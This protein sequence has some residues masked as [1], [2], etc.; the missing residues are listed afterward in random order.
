MSPFWKESTKKKIPYDNL[1]L[2]S[3]YSQ[4]FCFN[5]YDCITWISYKINPL[6]H[7][8]CLMSA[9][10]FQWIFLYDL[11]RISGK[12]E[13]SPS[14]LY[15]SLTHEEFRVPSDNCYL[16]EGAMK[17]LQDSLLRFHSVS[18][19]R[20]QDTSIWRRHFDVA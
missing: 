4:D 3:L 5:A 19:A 14:W 6:V 8:S 12:L 16:L 20:I 2:Y 7:L 15:I 18:E 9:L 11:I 10:S 17:E 13:Q 1:H